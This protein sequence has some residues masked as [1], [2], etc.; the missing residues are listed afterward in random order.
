MN[1]S[2]YH[3]RNIELNFLEDEDD[4][5]FLIEAPREKNR[6]APSPTCMSWMTG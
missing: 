3:L 5:L 4:L 6:T 2:A 1:A